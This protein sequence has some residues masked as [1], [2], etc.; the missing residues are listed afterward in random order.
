MA[1]VEMFG[2][3]NRQGGGGL[4]GHGPGPLG[5]GRTTFSAT[6][7]GGVDGPR[8]LSS[9]GKDAPGRSSSSSSPVAAS[10]HQPP[11]SGD[12]GRLVGRKRPLVCLRRRLV[13]PRTR[14]REAAGLCRMEPSL[15][16]CTHRH[17]ARPPAALLWRDGAVGG[18]SLFDLIS[19]SRGAQARGRS[20]AS[21]AFRVDCE[22]PASGRFG[23]PCTI[24]TCD[25]QIRGSHRGE[26][27]PPPGR[28]EH[29]EGQGFR[30]ERRRGVA[31]LLCLVGPG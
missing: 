17:P 12:A 18:P 5:V 1:I 19:R 30:R 6:C 26:G 22:A 20:S 28:P 23:A 15:L 10:R 29:N 24:R 4:V 3:R 16:H 2:I 31:P 8:G 13:A 21:W 25:L 14:R 7:K 27:R 11:R 9:P